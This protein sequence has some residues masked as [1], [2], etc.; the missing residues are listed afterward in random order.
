M[1]RIHLDLMWVIATPRAFDGAVDHD[2]LYEELNGFVGA[3]QSSF[4][5][6]NP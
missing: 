3:A 5:G 6:A 1:I 2:L 4:S